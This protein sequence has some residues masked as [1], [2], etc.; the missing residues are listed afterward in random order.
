MLVSGDK[1]FAGGMFTAY[2]VSNSLERMALYECGAIT[3]INSI[4]TAGTVGAPYSQSLTASSL[5]A[6]P[7][8]SV[9]SGS[10]PPG[11]SL[12]TTSGVLSGTPTQGGSFQFQLSASASACTVNK[13][14]SMEI[15]CPDFLY[16]PMTISATIPVYATYSQSFTLSIPNASAV[17]KILN[18][19]LPPGLVQDSITGQITGSPTSTGVYPFSIMA[20]ISGCTFAR[21]QVLTVNCGNPSM[22]PLTIPNGTVDTAYSQQLSAANFG[23]PASWSITSGALPAGLS[24]NA[25]TGLISGT[26]TTPSSSTFTVLANNGQCSISR[27]YSN[28]VF[29]NTITLSPSSLPNGR[30]GTAWVHNLSQTGITGTVIWEVINGSLPPGVTLNLTSG[31]LGGTPTTAGTYSFTIRATGNFSC[32]KEITYSVTICPN[33]SVLPVSIANSVINSAFSQQFTQSALSGTIAWSVSAGSLPPGLSLDP[34]TGLLSGTPSQIGLFTFTI[35]AS[36]GTCTV[37]RNFA[38]RICPEVTI[39]NLPI[40]VAT[41]GVPYN[42]TLTQTGYTGTVTWTMSNFLGLNITSGGTLTGTPTSATTGSFVV[43]ISDGNCSFT[44]PLIPIVICNPVTINP[45]TL[46]NTTVGATYNQSL[47]ASGVAGPYTWSVTSGSLPLGITLNSSTGVLSGNA[48]SSGNYAFTIGVS[49][50]GNN[51]PGSRSYTINV[52]CGT[53][54]IAPT[55]LANGNLGTPYSVQLIANGLSPTGTTWTVASGNLPAGLTLNSSTGEISGTPTTAGASAFTIA[56][57]GGGCSASQTL[58]ITICPS[59]S[60][61][62]T[63]VTQCAGTSATF[64]VTVSGTG[65]FT[66]QWKSGS[67]TISG[68]TNAS[69]TLSNLLAADA[70]YYT[71]DVTSSCGTSSSTAIAVVVNPLTT[72][73]TQPSAQALCVGANASFTVAANGTGSLSY[74]WKKAGNNIAGATNSTYTINNIAASDAA[75]YSVEVTGTCG[76]IASNAVALTLNTPTSITTQPTALVQC[77][78]TNASF[79]VVAAGTGTLSY[80]W[81][82][83]GNAISGATNAAYTINN[84]N[85]TDAGNFTVDVIGLCGTLTSNSVSLTV[86]PVTA[87]TTQPVAVTQ[88]AGTNATFWVVGTGTGTLTYQWKKAGSNIAGATNASFT[89]NSIST[90]D[91]ANYSVEVSSTCG[92]LNSNGVALTV[93][94]A[95]TITTQPVASTTCVGGSVTFSVTAFGQGTLTYQWKKGGSNISTATNS[96]YTINNVSI[97]DAGNFSVE[98]VGACGTV[99][100]NAVALTVNTST[101]INVQ[102]A[103]IVQCAG[104]NATFSVSAAGA[105]TLTYQWKKAGNNITGATN[106]SLTLNAITAVDAANYSVEVSSQCGTTL[107]NTASLTVNPITVISIQP[108]SQAL[109]AGANATFSVSATGTG[110]LTYQWKKGGSNILGATNASLTINSIAASDAADYTVEVSSTCGTVTSSIAALTLNQATT[111]TTQ[112][113]ALTQCA[114]TNASFSV[115]ANGSGTLTYQWKKVGNNIS[116]AT[117]STLILNT[118]SAIDV[119]NYSVDVTALCGTVVSSNASLTVNSIT[120]ITTQPSALTQCSNT[121]AIFTV[122]ATGTGTL[123]YQWRKAGIN[124]TGA[125]NAS[126]TL[127]NIVSADAANYSVV[128]TGTCGSITSANAALI[129]NPLTTITSQPQATT[130]CLGANA[131]FTVSATGTGAISYQWKKGGVNIPSATN[132]NLT[133]SNLVPGDAANY[134]V[135]VTASCGTVTSNNATLS[136]NNPVNITTQPSALTQCAGTNALFNVSATGTGT[137]SYQWRKAGINIPG[138]TNA[139]L[140]LNNINASDAALYAVNVNNVC[141]TLTSANANL[142]INPITTITTQPSA[143][144]LCVGLNANFSVV[145]AG[146]GSLTYQ[147]RKD[148]NNIVGANNANLTI[149]PLAVVDAGN[150]TVVVT[151]DCGTVTS[152]A[153]VLTINQPVSISM[154]GQPQSITQ[155]EGTNATFTVNAT[156]TGALTYQWQ[157]AGMNIPGAT[158]TTLALNAISFADA[159]NYT[160]LVTNTCNANTS[161]AAQLVVNPLTQ[162]TIQPQSAIICEGSTL[163]LSG[164]AI[165]TGTITYQWQK[166]GI[167]IQSETNDTLVINAIQISDIGAYQFIATGLCGIIAS[168]TAVVNLNSIFNLND[169]AVICSGSQFIFGSQIL[170]A[171]GVYTETFQSINGCD[172]VVTLTLTVNPT[173]NNNDNAQ[174]CD[175]DVYVFGTQNLTTTGVYTEV[176]NSI[177]GCDSTVVLALT[178]VDIDVVINVN[179]NTLSVPNVTGV[180]YQWIDCNSNT[181]IAGATNAEYTANENGRYQVEVSFNGCQASSD[182]IEITGISVEDLEIGGIRAY[183]NPTRNFLQISGT[184]NL[185]GISLINQF[186]VVVYDVKVEGNN[187]EISIGHLPGGVYHLQVVFGNKRHNERIVIQ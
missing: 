84:I 109:C 107:S 77:A 173:F 65:P 186:G 37:D 4:L 29:C 169:Q 145:A 26:P 74:Q 88:C 10:L 48:N 129:V 100:S 78:G 40:P 126:L 42:H 161:A 76:T 143:Q 105:G 80:Q 119:A 94:P 117:N 43:N 141:G 180:T 47:T 123:S 171:A 159:G 157:K 31:V 97:A 51:C 127:N 23:L 22:L 103:P 110:A 55:T 49:A 79:S 70:G 67:N 56:A 69:L 163:M 176:F 148:G 138:A 36:N 175:G 64:N 50:G 68:A 174:I 155:C 154:Q 153:A 62:P 172:S 118:I 179:Q 17:Y 181:A 86:N 7:T 93:Q 1:L 114:G 73:I 16:S 92:S 71:V 185:T 2:Q 135:E 132:S 177:T 162:V 39:G 85:A 34:V 121:N 5:G 164:S 102:P 170:T 90:A 131:T 156:G 61:S 60:V 81:K 33:A 95:T 96:T 25:S 83:G 112:P 20:Q 133:L 13:N 11:I 150:Y 52:N 137:L 104:T 152:Q 28:V 160:V 14:Y 158:Q 45:T 82:K 130:Q 53:T 108:Q 24:L 184:F 19:N 32:T 146:T 142:T 168:D 183:P 89:I 58:S 182:C 38:L 147:W 136:L 111:I 125:T 140:T 87:I 41:T 30:A 72:I 167:N 8:W 3:P 91:A 106:S 165:G 122:L 149:G 187:Q 128:V 134:T 6:N 66:Y 27:I 98:V 99:L 116:G 21:S 151:G 113:L 35:Q 139:S 144:A 75:N 101:A 178:V 54:S 46:S 120:T 63:S 115:V 59:I 166:D 44:S 12:N 18:G 9:V 124:I 15:D 57:N